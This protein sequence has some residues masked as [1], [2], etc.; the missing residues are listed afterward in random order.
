[1]F[2][3]CVPIC[4]VGTFD[5]LASKRHRTW[6]PAIVGGLIAILLTVGYNWLADPG[7]Y[8]FAMVGIGG[9]IAGSLAKRHSSR[10]VTAGV[11]AGAIGT[12]PGLLS[13]VS[14]LY[15]MVSEWVA[16]GAVILSII[17]IPL[18]V[19]LI[20]AMG[21]VLGLIGAVIGGWVTD[22]TA[23]RYHASNP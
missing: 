17:V 1:M 19:L 4:I 2:I 11:V 16:S 3:E 15:Q 10:I 6:S 22:L 5:Q 18:S 20:L 21:G 7:Y 12:L 14:P 9:L 23:T 13:A 8:S